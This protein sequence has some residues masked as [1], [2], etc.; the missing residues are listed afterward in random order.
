MMD[1]CRR[2]AD[3]LAS[4]AD[5][6]LPPTERSEL[7]KHLAACP[8]CRR[9]AQRERGG[10][11]LLRAHATEL[12]DTPIPP[13]LRSRCEALA[14]T[15]TPSTRPRVGALLRRP[16]APLTA[17]A[18]AVLLV[19]VFSLATHR[20]DTLLAAQ[21]TA[22][23]AKCFRLFAR[24]DAADA[25]ARQIEKSLAA[26][27]GWNVHVPPSSVADGVQLI[28]ARRCV[29]V[30]GWIPHVMYRANGHDMSLYMLGGVARPQ[31]DVVSL[32]HRSHMWT[33]GDTTYVLVWPITAG[34]LAQATRYVMAAA[35]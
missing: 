13:G 29:Y 6:L 2:A 3:R 20:S 11:M 4:F 33:R 19:A 25:D 15:R 12:T 26:D 7:E 30:D 10:R 32:G 27:Y 21:L 31:A 34:D 9:A 5:D 14:N 35:R 28:G 8:P 24:G 1:D 17:V 18:T 23:H 22:D 16:F